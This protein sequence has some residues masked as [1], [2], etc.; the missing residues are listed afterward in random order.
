MKDPLPIKLGGIAALYLFWLVCWLVLGDKA[1][2]PVYYN[3]D[4]G[5][6][7]AVTAWKSYALARKISE[8]YAIFLMALAIGTAMLAVSWITYDPYNSHVFFHFPG[9]DLPDYSAISYALFV[10]CWVFAWG[11]LALIQ[12]QHQ[13][14]S[15]LTKLVFVTLFF[16]LAIILA[17][18]YYPLYSQVLDTVDG[19]L[20][21]ATSCLEFI[22]LI[23]GL[24]CILLCESIILTWMLLATALLL[25]TDMAYSEQNVPV[26][27]EA[28]WMF[29][30][31]LLFSAILALPVTTGDERTNRGKYSASLDEAELRRSGLS[32]ILI[33]LS[34]G[35]LLLS[36]ALGLLPIH[37][38][39]KSFS[40][41]IFVVAFVAVQVWITDR[42][43]DTVR[44]L[45]T[46]TMQA[47]KNRLQLSDW[48]SADTPIQATLRST[49]LGLY[50]DWLR[51]AMSQ[52]KKD[53]L[54]LGPERLYPVPKQS[55]GEGNIR[56]FIVMPFS[57]DWSDAVHQTL[58]SSC[59]AL[60]V[61]PMRGDDVFTPTDILVDIW[62][63]INIADFVIADITGRNPNVLYELGIAHTL[64]KPVLI[65]SQ[66]VTDIPIDLSTRRVIIYGQDAN[67]WQDTLE[68][69]VSMA[70]KEIFSLYGL[71]S[72]S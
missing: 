22:V 32:G 40:A 49:G 54:F 67:N 53:V 59:K 15:A 47:H 29:G 35:G 2:G 72:A 50:L 43:D 13:P 3:W 10:F 45:K 69:K 25:A 65:V 30:Q 1:F 51:D 26:G 6:I 62:Q 31:M 8:P 28:V 63:S 19:R 57:H 55:G 9:Q 11:Y 34:L 46:F 52:L 12:W 14:P 24:A 56:C 27:V 5:L 64:A 7:T 38:I 17:N 39:W 70:I 18:F 23:V 36:V 16:G 71:K 33:L 41:V 60:A 4:I 48:R 20:D 44:F 21:A 37:P 66:S 42:F 68:N 58:S 61:Q